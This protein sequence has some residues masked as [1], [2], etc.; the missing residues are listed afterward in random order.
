MKLNKLQIT[1]LQRMQTYRMESPTLGERLRLSI[2]YMITLLVPVVVASALFISFGVP[3]AV[4][5]LT[6][7]YVGAIAREIGQQRMFLQWWPMTREITD[8]SK[9]EQALKD[10]ETQASG[11]DVASLAPTVSRTR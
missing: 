7:V 10:G 1:S 9:V 11:A 5:V 8:W 4:Y 2:G 6:G 3:N